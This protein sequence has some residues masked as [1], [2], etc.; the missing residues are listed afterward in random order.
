MD[1][2]E[3]LKQGNGRILKIMRKLED[4]T[5]RQP[6]EREE[7]LRQATLHLAA[8]KKVEEDRF[9]PLLLAS[10]KTFQAVSR[11]RHEWGEIE[12][13]VEQL[14]GSEKSDPGCRY[15]LEYLSSL[16]QRHVEWEEQTLFRQARQ[17]IPPEQAEML[18]EAAEREQEEL[19]HR[20]VQSP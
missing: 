8:Q 7:L 20:F 16:V 6:Q 3:A 13:L 15:L 18:G 4:T 10:P 1:I 14:A 2:Y 19:R 17:V 11:A 5:A 12:D 9:Y